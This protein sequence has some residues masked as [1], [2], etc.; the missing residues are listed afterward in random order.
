[1]D[2]STAFVVEWLPNLANAATALGGA[3]IVLALVPFMQARKQRLRDA[4]QWYVD[5]YW[6]IQDRIEVGVV[7]GRLRKMPTAKDMYDE[8]RLC[9]DELDQ[10]KSGFITDTTWDLWSPSIAAVAEDPDKMELL[11]R[12]DEL[13]LLRAY[14]ETE[15][16]DP[17]E[18]GWVRAQL[19][20]LH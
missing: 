5:R 18:I 9:E 14:L 19:R 15:G 17:I 7:D 3:A 11:R 12:A 4:E 6:A 20:G 16:K 10:R 8:L 1:M 2:F 13:S